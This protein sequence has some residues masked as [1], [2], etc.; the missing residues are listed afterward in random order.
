MSSRIGE[1]RQIKEQAERPAKSNIC[2][3]ESPAAA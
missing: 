2:S 1:T 3:D